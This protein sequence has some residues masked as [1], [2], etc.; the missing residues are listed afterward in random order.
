MKAM[1][2]NEVLKK[3]YD[4]LARRAHSTKELRN[5]LY[6]R[7]YPGRDIDTVISECTRLGFLNDASFARDYAAELAAQ[8]KGPFRIQMK[9]RAKGLPEN[10]IDQA[11]TQVN[12]NEQE[13]AEQALKGKIRSLVN[14]PDINKRRRKACRFLAYRGFSADT[15]SRLMENTPELQF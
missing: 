10:C 7:K 6:K 8:G 11:L 5:K 1:G 13:N 12:N 4:L 2:D 9:L 15:I 3:A 14:E